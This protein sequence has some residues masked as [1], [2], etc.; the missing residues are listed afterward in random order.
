MQSLPLQLLSVQVVELSAALIAS[1]VSADNT[2]A[3]KSKLR[4]ISR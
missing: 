4:A 2:P 1:A 3:E